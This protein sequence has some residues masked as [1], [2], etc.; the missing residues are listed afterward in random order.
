[1]LIKNI[2][3]Y[4]DIYGK[5]D[6]ILIVNKDDI[7]EFSAIINANHAYMR[8]EDIFGKNLYDLYQNLNE[9]NS[10]HARVMKTGIPIINEKQ[11]IVEK[12]GKSFVINTSTFPIENKGEI[13]GTIDISFNLT[14][15]DSK[16]EEEKRKLYT[17]DSIVTNSEHMRGLKS[18]ILKVAQTDSPVMVIGESGTGKELVVEAIHN[19]STRCKHPFISLNC[20]A[21]PDS[22]MESILFGTMKGSFTGAE[23]RK[24]IFELANRGTLFLDELNSMNIELQAKLLKVVEEQ[25]YMK[26]G[27]ETYIDV[28]V[29]IISAMNVTPAEARKSN[30]LRNDLFYRLG[31]FQFN[32]LPLRER[33]EDI[34]LL[35]SFFVEFYN[36][37][38]GRNIKGLH[39]LVL[40]AFM[41]YDWPGN[42]RELRNV[43]ESAFNI[44]EDDQIRIA[45]I[46]DYLISPKHAGRKEEYADLENG[47]PWLV[48]QFEKEVITKTLSTVKTLVEAAGVLKMT[49]Q[50]IKYKID[51]YHINY[52]ELMKR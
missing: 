17:V 45:D 35:A 22:L 43:I 25:K 20:A 23:N 44:A 42:V 39:G 34:G 24:G 30:S 38:M 13:I 21:V 26:L 36:A 31:V 15:D 8:T 14:Y 5:I 1:M 12:T 49:R 52:K 50:A 32:I 48:E 11:L 41:D 18:K 46:P 51:K 37:K 40:K 4:N 28:D 3:K 7:V 9:E 10:T 29:R 47:L 27:G 19:A 33:R 16:K 6:A 2:E